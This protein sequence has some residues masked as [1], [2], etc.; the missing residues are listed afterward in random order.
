LDKNGEKIDITGEKIKVVLISQAGS[1]GL[2]FKAIRQIHILEPW[3]NMNRNEQIIGRGVRNFSHKDLPFEKRNVQ[4]FL[5][6]T[7]LKNKLEEA[8]DLYVYRM[9]EIKAVK[10]G[11]V[12]RLLKQTA[13]DC[14]INHEQTKFTPKNFKDPVKQV[15]SSGKE[16]NKFEIGDKPNTSNCDYMDTC[17]YK[18]LI[19]SKK[20][21]YFENEIEGA[22][23]Y[24]EKAIE[25]FGEYACLNDIP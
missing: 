18:C 15:L 5:Y 24:N 22:K 1:E 11:K 23:A 4:I 3:Y 10:I 14:I 9:A 2:D 13:V 25:L 7:I 8:A 19:D 20:E 17:E 12:T 6:G 21:I 16:L